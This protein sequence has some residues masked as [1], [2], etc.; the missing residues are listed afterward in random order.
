MLVGVDTN[1]HSRWWRPPDQ[2]S[3]ATGELADDFVITHSL[4]IQNR[5][6]A[7]ATFSS[8]RGFKAWLDV[9]MTSSRLHP[10]VSSWL[11]MDTN[12]GSDH[13]AILGSIA[14]CACRGS[15][16]DVRLDWRSVCWDSFCQ[17]LQARL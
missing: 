10:L 1:G 16:V 15:E 13:Y 12:L 6:P 7:P 4:E 9:T 8:D 11:V 5:W 17:A 14:T 2:A 3:N